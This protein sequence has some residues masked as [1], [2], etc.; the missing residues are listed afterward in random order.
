[1]KDK[2]GPLGKG[3]THSIQQNT[4]IQIISLEYWNHERNVFG[5]AQMPNQNVYRKK[6]VILAKGEI[7]FIFT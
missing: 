7:M 1:M 5:V 6:D 2:L 4:K 3:L